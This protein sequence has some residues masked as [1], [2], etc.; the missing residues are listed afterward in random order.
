LNG[1]GTASNLSSN[2]KRQAQFQF[3]KW[4]L[5]LDLLLEYWDGYLEKIQ[6]TA[7]YLFVFK[8]IY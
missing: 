5:T 7:F 1:R 8:Q 2:F 4:S 6:K 3:L